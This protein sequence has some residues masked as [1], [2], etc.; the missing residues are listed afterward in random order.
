MSR[1]TKKDILNF[2]KLIGGRAIGKTLSDQ[3]MNELLMY[4]SIEDELGCP[5]EAIKTKTA[6]VVKDN[7]VVEMDIMAI[8]FNNGI[9][10]FG[11]MWSFTTRKLKDYKK[12]W[13]LKEDL[14]E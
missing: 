7:S 8:G 3:V 11:S 2:P 13:F 9:I 12:T 4:K 5:L 14:S 1:L 10:Y 6:M